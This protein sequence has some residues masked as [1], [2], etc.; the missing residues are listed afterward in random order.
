MARN[1]HK[2]LAG[3]LDEWVKEE[4]V[5]SQQAAA[6]RRRHPFLTEGG[7][8]WG[9]IIFSCLGAVIIGLG[10][11]LLLAYNW[12]K[13]HR[14]YKLGMIIGAIVIAHGIGLRLFFASTRYR[15]LGEALCLLG[16]MLF[17]AGIWLVAQIY[18]IEEHFTTAFLLWG[19]GAFLLALVMSSIPQ[20]ILSAVLI[21]TWCVTERVTF[22]VAMPVAP[23]LIFC[24]G[25][26]AWLKQSRILLAIV[27]PAF[28]ICFE[29]VVPHSEDV[30]SVNL[31]LLEI[32]AMLVAFQLLVRRVGNFPK[33]SAV[34]GFFGWVLFL[35]LVFILA[36]PDAYNEWML[37]AVREMSMSTAA[38][39]YLLGAACMA[40]W[41][42][43]LLYHVFR[44]ETPDRQL[45]GLETY[46]IPLTVL[47]IFTRLFFWP[48]YTVYSDWTIAAPLNMVFLVLSV[49]MI[50]RGCRRALIGPTVIGSLLLIALMLARFF[51]LF[52]SLV[53]RGLVFLVV[54]AGLFAEGIFYSRARR[55]KDEG[56]V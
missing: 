9:A 7:L 22:D 43:I 28:V 54:G 48:D 26:F 42:A 10:V 31:S 12:D 34:F 39:Q 56:A 32:G 8:P 44:V 29:V 51:D 46:L 15:N 17:G 5:T 23:L 52:G 37:G 50:T 11:I 16:T 36:F 4:I 3:Q 25:V 45:I 19:M 1:H 40:V 14:L 55:R 47:F 13:I 2:W 49:G 6:L 18:H 27:I 35:V 30:W 53:V 33:S 21:A 41:I 38:W 20:A 24:L